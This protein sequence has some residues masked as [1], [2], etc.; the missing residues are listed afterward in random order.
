MVLKIIKW[1]WG[2]FRIK[3]QIGKMKGKEIFE[4]IIIFNSATRS[5]VKMEGVKVVHSF[6][7]PN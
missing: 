6:I 7:A 2:V 4:K 5:L 3:G 1:P